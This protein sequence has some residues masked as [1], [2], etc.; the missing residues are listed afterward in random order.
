MRNWYA[1]R[2]QTKYAHKKNSMVRKGGG[3]FNLKIQEKREALMLLTPSTI[4]HHKATF[5]IEAQ[6]EVFWIKVGNF[7]RDRKITCLF[8]QIL[9]NSETTTHHGLLVMLL[10]DLSLLDICL[11]GLLL[12]LLSSDL[13]GRNSN[14]V[15]LLL[16]DGQRVIWR[17]L[18]YGSR[19]W[20]IGYCLLVLLSSWR[21]NTA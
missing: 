3:K 12:W 21:N 4:C 15:R 13:R 8:R 14:Y 6:K 10:H 1:H 20:T 18:R 5:V 17:L 11:L 19:H 16:V 7:V 2:M 9:I